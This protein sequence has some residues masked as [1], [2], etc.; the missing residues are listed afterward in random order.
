M[1]SLANLALTPPA[2]LLATGQAFSGVA[3]WRHS[4]RAFSVVAL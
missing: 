4:L 2:L 3:L 1:L